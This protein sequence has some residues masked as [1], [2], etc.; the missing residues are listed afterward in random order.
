MTSDN[1]LHVMLHMPVDQQMFAHSQ[2]DAVN[3]QVHDVPHSKHVCALWGQ[4]CLHVKLLLLTAWP[5]AHVKTPTTAILGDKAVPAMYPTA[6]KVPIITMT[7][8]PKLI[9]CLY[10][11]SAPWRKAS[12]ARSCITDCSKICQLG[13]CLSSC[14]NAFACVPPAV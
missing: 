5:K 2:C 7:C 1:S 12:A 3:I 9:C 8:K 10:V 4:L 6:K 11:C 14:K 13:S